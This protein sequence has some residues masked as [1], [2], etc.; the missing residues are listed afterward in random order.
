MEFAIIA[1]SNIYI[2]EKQIFFSIFYAIFLTL[3]KK[4]T[5]S[6]I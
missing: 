4:Y 5:V 6:I 2:N 1:S 3:F